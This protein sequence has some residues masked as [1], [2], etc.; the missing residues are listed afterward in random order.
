MIEQRELYAASLGPVDPAVAADPHRDAYFIDQLPNTA[1]QPSA[2]SFVKA[3]KGVNM[4]TA[5]IDTV[6]HSRELGLQEFPKRL[7]MLEPPPEMEQAWQRML[8]S[9]A[10]D[11]VTSNPSPPASVV[12]SLS[13]GSSSPPSVTHHSPPFMAQPSPPDPLQFTP[14]TDSS[15]PVPEY[16]AIHAPLSHASVGSETSVFEYPGRPDISPSSVSGS[17]QPESSVQSPPSGVPSPDSGILSARS[18]SSTTGVLSPP[19]SYGSNSPPGSTVGVL[20]PETLFSTHELDSHMD[21]TTP[22]L[23]QRLVQA[24][25][26]GA[27][28]AEHLMQTS[29]PGSWLSQNP[30]APQQDVWLTQ[31][32]PPLPVRPLTTSPDD[33]ISESEL[34]RLLCEVVALNDYSNTT[35]AVT[36][37]IPSYDLSNFDAT[38]WP[39]S[40]SFPLTNSMPNPLTYN[41]STSSNQTKAQSTGGTL[42]NNHPSLLDI[43]PNTLTY[44]GLFMVDPA[45][46]PQEGPI[47]ASSGL[48]QADIESNSEVREILQQF[49]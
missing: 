46:T 30:A 35:L 26:N 8:S 43:D 36:P 29:V 16:P 10:T 21:T 11:T 17:K 41:H 37:T 14:S 40:G 22:D 12:S 1:C 3:L 18:S 49:M 48:T 34:E 4:S 28:N 33:G 19:S 9:A 39:Q 5:A 23:S 42:G 47:S 15:P 27:Y 20:S 13:S 24:A 44:N 6:L 2:E 7:K 25:G 31:N 45:Q 32:P 38:I